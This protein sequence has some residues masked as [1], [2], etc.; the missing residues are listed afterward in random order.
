MCSSD[1]DLLL[2]A[3]RHL[4]DKGRDDIQFV[5]VGGGPALHELREM[6]QRMGISDRVTFTDRAPDRDL[7]EVLSTADVCVN[8][9]R[10]NPMNDKSTMNKILEYMA[11]E[12]PIVQF[13]VT[14]G[15]YSAAE[16]SLYA[17][18]S[19]SVDLA[20]KI[21]EL[22]AD[23]DKRALMGAI[24]RKRVETLFAWPFQV[25]PLIAAYQRILAP[26]KG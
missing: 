12:K 26:R 22:L 10:V 11:F 4:A 24:G 15:R 18:S 14:E 7:F 19:D 25:G 6:A 9:D 3:V 20:D 21:E 23:A 16:A 1:L 8:P 17:R 13:E 2:A 5:L